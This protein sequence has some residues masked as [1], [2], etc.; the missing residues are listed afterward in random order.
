MFIKLPNL[1]IRAE[2]RL[3]VHHCLLGRSEWGQVRRVYSKAQAL[4]QCRNWL[5]KNVPQAAKVEVVSTAA[6]AEL[7][8]REEFA[9]AVASRA[10]AVAYRLNVLAEN[11]E[12]QPHNVT[13]FAVIAEKPGERTGRDKTT[14]MLRL[15]NEAGSLVR[16]I[17][18]FEK[19]GVNMTWIESFPVPNGSRDRDP[20]YLFFVDV[21]GY[22]DDPPV[23]KALELVRKRCERLDILGSYPR[24]ECIES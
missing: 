12:D 19:L 17:A 18:P 23:Q 4:S 20:S 13:R 24:S 7:A 8:Q 10:A 16:T 6:A 3:R 1:K 21:D 2:I 5:G 14:L 22:V 11:I 15:A 9:A